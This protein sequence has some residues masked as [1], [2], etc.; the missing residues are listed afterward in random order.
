[1]GFLLALYNYVRF[2]SFTEFGTSYQLLGTN[3]RT[4]PFNQL[5]YIPHGVY[6]FLFS[7]PHFSGSF[8]YLF[9]RPNTF[10]VNTFRQVYQNEPV[11]GILTSMPVITVGLV[12]AL[13]GRVQFVRRR[14][15]GSRSSSAC[16]PSSRP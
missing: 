11:A 12:M 7:P 10:D 6:Y 15:P 1:M 14:D 16:A 5:W 8:P 9:L 13:G 3:P 2:D 4:Y